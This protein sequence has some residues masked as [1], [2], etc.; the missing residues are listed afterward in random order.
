MRLVLL[1]VRVGSKTVGMMA[2]SVLGRQ[3]NAMEVLIKSPIEEQTPSRTMRRMRPASQQGSRTTK[4][5]VS[6]PRRVRP[7]GNTSRM[8]T[9][10]LS[11][12]AT[13]TWVDTDR[14]RQRIP[15]PPRLETADRRSQ[16]RLEH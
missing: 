10:I 3:R 4:G 13:G 12:Y 14:I 16:S 2:F 6:T 9:G 15:V 5:T 11:R 7:I 1:A 8:D